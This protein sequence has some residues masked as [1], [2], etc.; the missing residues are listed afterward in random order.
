VIAHRL[1]T[2][3]NADRILVLDKGRIIEQGHHQELLAQ[4]GAYRKLYDLQ[5]R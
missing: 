5:F 3:Q 2:I 1:S 4:N